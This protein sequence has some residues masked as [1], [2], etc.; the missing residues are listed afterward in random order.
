MKKIFLSILAISLFGCEQNDHDLRKTF[1]DFEM[2]TF[3]NTQEVNAFFEDGGLAEIPVGL[4]KPLSEDLTVSIAVTD[5]TAINGVH[6]SF[7][8]TSIVIPAGES[9]GSFKLMVVNDEEINES[10]E[11]EI[12][13]SSNNP[14]VQLGLSSSVGSTAKTIVLANDD[15][16]TNF[17]VFIGSVSVEDFGFETTPG[18][19]FFNPRRDCNI[20]RIDNNLPALGG[21]TN[22]I[23]DIEL[24]PDFEEATT[25]TAVVARTLVRA[26]ANAAGNLDAFYQASGF[27]D[28][29]T[30][31]ITLDYEVVAVDNVTGNSPGNFYDG[32]NIITVV[33]SGL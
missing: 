12:V 14:A 25:G 21:A 13:L 23:F 11:F 17:R 3:V 4:S 16:T 29:D 8:S 6:Y 24:I 15:C 22:T 18:V 19:T 1:S 9:S 27:Y 26:R 2:V 10:R 7:E 32:Q 5:G 31:T 28:E 30:K 20:V 33:S